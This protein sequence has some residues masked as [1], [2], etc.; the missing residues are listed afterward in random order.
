MIRFQVVN[1]ENVVAKIVVHGGSFHADD[2]IATVLAIV[3]FGKVEVDRVFS[4]NEDIIANADYIIDVGEIYDGIKFFDHHQSIELYEDGV[5]P[6]GAT[7]FVEKI[8]PAEIYNKLYER[9]LKAI[10]IQDNGQVEIM[11]E[12]PNLLLGWI[13]QMNPIWNSGKSFDECCQRPPL[14]NAEV[15]A[16]GNKSFRRNLLPQLHQ[17]G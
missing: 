8:F 5:H 12:N 10:A 4:V 2:V 9:C 15:G 6:C 3:R 13:S 14:A 7:L 17:I 1:A 11:K 16:C